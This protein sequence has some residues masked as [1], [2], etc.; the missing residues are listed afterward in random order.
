[1]CPIYLLFD[2]SHLASWNFS[3]E[4]RLKSSVVVCAV[5]TIVLL[6]RKG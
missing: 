3:K 4:T 6:F 2:I 5:C 1:M